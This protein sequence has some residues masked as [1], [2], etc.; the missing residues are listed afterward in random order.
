MHSPQDAP[1]LMDTPELVA[2]LRTFDCL[3]G[4]AAPVERFDLKG[5]DL[6]RVSPEMLLATLG[7]PMDPEVLLALRNIQVEASSALG[8]VPHRRLDQMKKGVILSAERGATNTVYEVAIVASDTVV[9]FSTA[10]TQ[11]HASE[12]E[13][14]VHPLPRGTTIDLV[15]QGADQR[16]VSFASLPSSTVTGLWPAIEAELL[17]RL[18]SKSS[19]L[20]LSQLN[21]Y[22]GTT[23]DSEE[24]DVLFVPG[25]ETTN[26]TETYDA[27][28]IQARPLRLTFQ[29]PDE[30]SLSG[31]DRFFQK[32]PSLDLLYSSG[33]HLGSVPTFF[34]PFSTSTSAAL[35]RHLSLVHT[36]QRLEAFNELLL[37]RSYELVQPLSTRLSGR[38]EFLLDNIGV[39]VCPLSTV[40]GSS[41]EQGLL[42]FVSGEVDDLG[43]ADLVESDAQIP[44]TFNPVKYAPLDNEALLNYRYSSAQTPVLF[45][46]FS[47]PLLSSS[48]ETEKDI[49]R[50]DIVTFSLTPMYGYRQEQHMLGIF[51]HIDSSLI[52][53]VAD[54]EGLTSMGLDPRLKLIHQARRELDEYVSS[55]NKNGETYMNL[56][57]DDIMV[58]QEARLTPRQWQNI[59]RDG[60]NYEGV[61]YTYNDTNGYGFLKAYRPTVLSNSLSLGIEVYFKPW[62]Q[63]GSWHPQRGERV[64]FRTKWLASKKNASEVKPQ[65]REVVPCSTRCS[66]VYLGQCI[67]IFPPYGIIRAT[68]CIDGTVPLSVSHK[69][70]D[71][72]S[73]SLSEEARAFV[74]GLA[75][76]GANFQPKTID[77]GWMDDLYFARLKA[78]SHSLKRRFRIGCYLCFSAEM[79]MS[80]HTR[81]VGL[82][83]V[84]PTIY[85]EI[86]A[87]FSRY[88]A[89]IHLNAGL[90]W[91]A[92]FHPPT[93]IEPFPFRAS[94]RAIQPRPL[95]ATFGFGTVSL[96]SSPSTDLP[97]YS[98]AQQLNTLGDSY[99]LHGELRKEH[100]IQLE[101]TPREV[102]SLPD[103]FIIQPI[104]M[105]TTPTARV[106]IGQGPETELPA[107]GLL[108]SEQTS[109]Y[110]LQVS[111][112]SRD[113]VFLNNIVAVDGY[114]SPSFRRQHLFLGI[115]R[116]IYPY[117]YALPGYIVNVSFTCEKDDDGKPLL[118]GLQ[119]CKFTVGGVTKYAISMSPPMRVTVA[120]L[121]KTGGV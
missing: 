53:P 9:T 46:I 25:S 22:A 38:I 98:F 89:S 31:L 119:F 75:P 76:Y 39:I 66:A 114:M 68:I 82:S 100:Q 97:V 23:T 81:A 24:C 10:S 63:G 18:L 84:D 42:G 113:H 4:L 8:P 19:G 36:T 96:A 21:K 29:H 110:F 61:I 83:I 67:G 37:A 99:Q 64:S 77:K 55:S 103:N 16:R 86:A 45:A 94:S 15:L 92:W 27:H 3:R 102:I 26:Y 6:Y 2:Y 108:L 70:E 56:Y 87:Y 14:I 116:S 11:F 80:T 17:R 13:P 30:S 101:T 20:S 118:S 85:E 52:Y 50:G 41:T 78:L 112:F 106:L 93:V 95:D 71:E 54:R 107:L 60:Q 117:R 65:G 120:G 35:T 57:A 5:V 90:P 40:S 51:G 47:M 28:A 105:Y 49:K 69:N 44:N 33:S 115:H 58:Q 32:E 1:Y 7:S 12:Q 48:T 88:D 91:E 79:D 62:H 121:Q 73:V 74:G 104:G 109:T 111:Y 43:C 59:L 72:S 34:H